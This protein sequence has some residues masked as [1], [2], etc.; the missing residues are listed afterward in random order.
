[1][2][3]YRPPEGSSV[4]AFQFAL[5]L[6][7]EQWSAVRRHWGARRFAFN[8]TVETMQADL[9]AHAQSGASTQRPS[10]YGLRKRWNAEKDTRCVNAETKALWWP[11][12]SKEAF[13]DGIRGAVAGY[14]NWHASKKGTRAG[15]RMGF[16]HFA[17]KGQDPDRLTFTTG[18][19]KV[20][21]DRHHITL[22]RLGTLRSFENTCKLERLVAKG[23]A[24]ILAVSVRR[25]GRRALASFRV[26]VQRRQ[27]AHPDPRSFVGVDLGIRYLATTALSDGRVL[28]HVP[29][30]APLSNSLR[31]LRRLDRSIARC[32]EGSWNRRQ[33][34]IQRARLQARIKHIRT[35]A[36]HKLTTALAKT[37]GWIGLASLS[38][39]GMLRQRNLPGARSRRRSLSDAALGEI[40]RQLAYKTGWYGSHLVSAE[41]FYPSSKTCSVCAYVQDIGWAEH[42]LC[43]N[44]GTR[45]QRDDNAAVNLARLAQ[46]Q[47]VGRVATPVKCGAGVRPGRSQAVGAEAQSPDVP[48]AIGQGETGQLR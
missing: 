43:A 1:M 45:H 8:W 46:R 35:D 16:V 21:P 7:P 34:T 26:A 30:P 2:R 29:N 32:V 47:A 24:K 4:Q 13:A 20:Q 37:H 31:D 44:C 22:P 23:Q 25:D 5:D 12:V 40:L 38:V 14:W 28:A 11:E 39:A 15:E 9:D 17:K 3:R 41:R 48:L 42:W 6:D 10:L 27:R 19:M 33:R 36:Q 18:V